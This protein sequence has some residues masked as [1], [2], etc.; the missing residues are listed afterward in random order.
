MLKI[1]NLNGFS[2]ISSEELAI[3][4]LLASPR[5]NSTANAIPQPMERGGEKLKGKFSGLGLPDVTH[6]QVVAI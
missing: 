4:Y 1:D 2:R 5:F 3:I 6:F